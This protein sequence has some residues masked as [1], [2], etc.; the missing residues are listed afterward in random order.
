MQLEGTLPHFPVSATCPYPEPAQCSLCLPFHF[1]KAHLNIIL[2]S[3]PG[4]SK[5]SLS[6]M[7]PHKNS[8]C[9]SPLP[10]TCCMPH[11]SP[12]TLLDLITRII[13]S[14]KC[15]SLSSSLCSF[16]TPLLRCP[17]LAQ[18]FSSAPYS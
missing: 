7:F 3:T 14:E 16:C 5:W 1:L 4:S 15:R 17:Y 6:L 13:F 12:L 18:I 8:V 2:P 9:T 10:H 11:P